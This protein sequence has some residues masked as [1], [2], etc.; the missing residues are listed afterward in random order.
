MGQ[1]TTVQN[2]LLCECAERDDV[3][4]MR[5]AL[6]LGANVHYGCHD[7]EEGL[8]HVA[9][10]LQ[11]AASHGSVNAIRLLAANGVDI[12]ADNGYALWCAASAGKLEAVKVIVD[13]YGANLRSPEGAAIIMAASMSGHT[14]VVEFLKLAEARPAQVGFPRADHRPTA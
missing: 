8:I 2:I 13:E 1:E 9:L 3:A 11:A 14:D 4:G 5:A 7:D 6:I 12:C 10:P